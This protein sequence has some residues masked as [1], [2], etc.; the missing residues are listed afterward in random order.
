MNKITTKD[1]TTGVSIELY[2]SSTDS[3]IFLKD[4]N[5][6]IGRKY[7]IKRIH[8]YESESDYKRLITELNTYGY[9]HGFLPEWNRI[10]AN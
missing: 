10:T 4:A 5:G 1:S 3:V 9:S 2:H 8:K 7:Y 6:I